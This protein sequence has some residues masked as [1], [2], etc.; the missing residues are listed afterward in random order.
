VGSLLLRQP[1]HATGTGTSAPRL[2][3]RSLRPPALVLGVGAAFIGALLV[4]DRP[5]AALGL[6][7]MKVDLFAFGGGFSSVPLMF[8][9]MVDARAWLPAAV[10]MDG[11]ALG[12]V[13]PGPIVITATFVGHQVA[14]IAGAVVGTACIFWPSFFA[15]VLV[16]PWFR[17]LHASVLFQGASR[18]IVLSFVGLLASV[19]GSSH[20]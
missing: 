9:E 1:A 19:T 20:A 11:I 14:G 16:E 8:R 4:L 5:L 17:W 6:A 2:G 7:M 10:F 3:W 18:G 12:Q 15:V 13:T